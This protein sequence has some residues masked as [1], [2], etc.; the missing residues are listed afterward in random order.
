MHG[1]IDDDADIG[2]ARRKRPDPGDGDRKN[3]LILD[4]ALDRLH[5]RIEA[6]DMA[7]HQR[8]AG[9]ARRG[10]D[11]AALLDGRGDRLLH[12]DVDAARGAVDGDIAMQMRGRRD[13]DGVDAVVQQRVG[14]VEG[15]ATEIAGDGLAALAVGI[16]DADQLHPRQFGQDAGMVTAHHAYADN[17][18]TQ[19]IRA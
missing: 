4:R 12:H 14:I 19:R 2:H 3:V 15:G 1:E 17:A 9:A 18:D 7:D 13:G 16:G 11:G 10:D 6:L 5:R 8:D